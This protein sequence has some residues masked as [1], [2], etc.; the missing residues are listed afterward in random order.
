MDLGSRK[1]SERDSS[2][3]G[4][5]VTVVSLS[6]SSRHGEWGGG[7]GGGGITCKT[8]IL[9][10]KNIN[11]LH[12]RAQILAVKTRQLFNRPSNE[13]LEV[14]KFNIL[15]NLM[16]NY[17]QLQEEVAMLDLAVRYLSHSL[18]QEEGTT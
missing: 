16:S 11:S 9:R 2:I 4:S 13:I 5:R 17:F 1:G 3:Q 8:C 18:A 6:Q 15:L 7:G 14:Q 10:E 12:F